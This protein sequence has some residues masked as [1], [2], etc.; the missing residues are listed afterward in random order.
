MPAARVIGEP[1][2]ERCREHRDIVHHHDRVII[3]LGG[4]R[5]GDAHD[6]GL[7]ERRIQRLHCRLEKLA[8]FESPGIT[9]L[10]IDHQHRNP[11]KDIGRGNRFVV[12]G[13]RVLGL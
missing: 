13:K 6:V 3:Q 12:R 7:D 11:L 4:C 9:Q 8:R 2:A 10:A 5:L 1:I